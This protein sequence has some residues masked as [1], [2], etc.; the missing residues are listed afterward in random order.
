MKKWFAFLMFLMLLGPVAICQV[1]KYD[2][3]TLMLAFQD[4]YAGAERFSGNAKW[5]KQNGESVTGRFVIEGEKFH[6]TWSDGEILSDGNIE[7]EIIHRSKRIKKRFYDP[8][9]TPALLMAFRFVR[10][11]LTAEP[12]HIGGTVD[13]IA[14]D[15]DFG[16]SVAQGAHLISIDAKTLAPTFIMVHVTQEGY[17]EKAEIAEVKAGDQAATADYTLDF[18]EWKKKGYT[19]TDMAKGESDAVWPEERALR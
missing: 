1:Q 11:D 3:V 16:S 12:V 17:F 2:P 7:Y 14:I 6:L 4:K 5:S 19:L 13:K 10:L 15:V 18:A 8:L 9:I